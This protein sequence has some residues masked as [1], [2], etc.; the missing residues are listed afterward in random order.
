MYNDT[1]AAIATGITNAGIGIIRISG[2]NAIS[3][4]DKIYVSCK[5]KKAS[6]LESHHLYLGNIFCDDEVYDEVLLSVMKAPHSYTGEDTVEINCHGGIY[7]CKKILKLVLDN[8]ARLSEPGEFTKRAFLNGRMD[9]SRAEAVMDLINAENEFA[10]KNSI[11]QLKGSVYKEIVELREKVL[12]ELAFIEAALDDPEHYDLSEY[13]SVLSDKTGAF[14]KNI[15]DILN[16]SERGSIMK[17]GIRTAILGKPNAGKSSVL[18]MLSGYDRA[19][20][21]DIAGTTRDII[22]ESV[23]VGDFQLN[24]TD[25]AGIRDTEDVVE[26]IGVDKAIEKAMDADLILFVADSSVGLDEND[27]QIIKL[28][29]NC[30]TIILFNKT[31]LVS[32]CEIDEIM[33]LFG[34]KVP[35]VEFSTK[36]GKGLAD[37]VD[38]LSESFNLQAFKLNEDLVITNIRQQDELK[39]SAESLQFVLDGIDNNMPED[40]LAV[41]LMDAYKHLGYIIG[42]EVEDD[43]V[44]KIFSEFCMGK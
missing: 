43:L 28:I 12:H 41:D 39:K 42:D 33:E 19:I 24:L 7:I 11:S 22:E 2:D 40:V 1:I 21:T 35:Y 15:N 26:K 13:S 18:N 16:A 30:K 23:R 31:D 17:N 44:N 38:K 20:V 36:S 27:K 5:G 6:E 3:V 34:K 37:F 25:T 8:G 10:A 14:I 4:I 32:E 29:R 9:L